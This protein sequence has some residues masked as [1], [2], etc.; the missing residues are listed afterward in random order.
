M[1]IYQTG[2]KGV[3]QKVVRRKADG[4]EM[5]IYEIQDAQGY[6]WTTTR[7]NIA[8]EAHRLVGQQVLLDGR[9][10]QNGTFTNRY[11]DDI[12]SAGDRS[13]FV[14]EP[15][16]APSFEAPQIPVQNG[17]NKQDQIHR[18]TAAKVSAVISGSAAE[19]WSNVD[20]LVEYFNSGS[21]P[22]YPTESTNGHGEFIPDE[23]IPVVSHSGGNFNDDDI[24]F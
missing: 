17:D 15:H 13:D 8:T 22:A 19:F 20:D 6:V 16:A 4:R 14:P 3:S 9:V 18:Q 2:V 5:T 1:P 21:K 24:P 10:E 7:K 12:K 11:L 23:P